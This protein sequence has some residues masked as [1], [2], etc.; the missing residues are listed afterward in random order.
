MGNK[1]FSIGWSHTCVVLSLK[2]Q[3]HLY[4]GKLPPFF[5]S[6]AIDVMWFG[7]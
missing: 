3:D 6:T 2:P 5:F 4:L 1:L 7:E